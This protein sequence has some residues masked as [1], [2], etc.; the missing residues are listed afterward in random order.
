MFNYA[1]IKTQIYK[2]RRGRCEDKKNFIQIMYAERKTKQ[3]PLEGEIC[4]KCF[5][6]SAGKQVSKH[7][8]IE[9]DS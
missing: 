2:H 5:H 9:F 8:L 1:V 3:L 7:M 6:D 4:C